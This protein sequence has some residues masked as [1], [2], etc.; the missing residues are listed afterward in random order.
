MPLKKFNC[1]TI[2]FAIW[3][4]V[5]AIVLSLTSKGEFELWFN[6]FHNPVL[7]FVFKY[8][9][10]IG[11]G[12][13]FFV[14]IVALL[15]YKISYGIL[16]AIV[17]ISV[18]LTSALCKQIFFQN[19]PRPLTFLSDH[20]QIHLVNGVVPLYQNSFPSGHTMS[21]FALFFLLTMLFKN[22]IAGTVFFVLA[23]AVALS[24]MYLMQH[25]LLDVFAGSILGFAIAFAWF[26]FFSSKLFSI[27]KLNKPLW[28]K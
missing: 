10:G 19:A 27:E 7:D 13:F 15:F 28:S 4:I 8:A 20:T 3:L 1:F 25:F 11:N 24:R 23:F 12:V 5:A 18:S 9:T 21:A 26:Y 22:K 6:S 2:P 14:I 17:G 16:A